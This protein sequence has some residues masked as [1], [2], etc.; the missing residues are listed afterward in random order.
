[1]II[2]HGGGVTTLY[3]HASKLYAEV[4]QSVE[5]GEV[6]ALMG[7]TGRSTGPHIHF[8]VRVNGRKDN[9]LRYAR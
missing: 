7:S 6:I 8:E 5:Q 3:G 2:D 1:V 4:G 9:P